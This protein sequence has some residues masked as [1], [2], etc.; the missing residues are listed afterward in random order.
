MVSGSS[1]E[2]IIF[3]AELCSAG[4][5]NGVVAGSH[6]SRCWTVHNNL[7]EALERLLLERFLSTVDNL[8]DLVD[9]IF[10]RLDLNYQSIEGHFQD[11]LEDDGIGEL[12]KAYS[13]FQ[14]GMYEK[15]FMAQQVSLDAVLS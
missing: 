8:R 6:Y 15:V 5:L 14:V 11:A 10:D 3:Q 1:F 12:L 9:N 2:D 13:R 7:T 4:S